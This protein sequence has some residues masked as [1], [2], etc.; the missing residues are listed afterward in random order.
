M[1]SVQYLLSIETRGI[2]LGLKRTHELMAVCGNPQS[3][4]PSIQVAAQ[5]AKDPFLQCWLIFLKLQITKQ[6]Y[7]PRLIW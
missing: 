6:V 4:L 7:L 2:K 3:N 1:N 5:M